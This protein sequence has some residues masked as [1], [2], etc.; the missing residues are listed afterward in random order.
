[1]YIGPWLRGAKV[2]ECIINNIPVYMALSV[3]YIIAL[4]K[5]GL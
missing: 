2:T 5:K 4:V 3:I 1:M